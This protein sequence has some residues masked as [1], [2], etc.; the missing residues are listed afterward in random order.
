[1]GESN[2]GSWRTQTPFSTTA[3]TA[4]PTEQ[5]VQMVRLTSTLPAP[6]TDAAFPAWAFFT[7]DNCV[8]AKPTPTPRP[9]RRKKLRRSNVGKACERPRRKLCTNED[10]GAPC[11]PVCFLVSNMKLS[12]KGEREKRSDQSG[13]VIALDVFAQNVTAPFFGFGLSRQ[14]G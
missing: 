1:M 13:L 9:E 3:S 12:R 6:N 11:V 10:E 7:S 5:W 8:A 2:T 4:H 14:F